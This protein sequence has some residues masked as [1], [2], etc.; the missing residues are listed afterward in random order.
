[1]K[2]QIFHSDK[3][4]KRARQLTNQSLSSDGLKLSEKTLLITGATQGIGHTLALTATLAGAQTLLLDKSIPALETLYE[5]IMGLSGTVLEPYLLP[6]D[7]AGATLDDYLEIAESLKQEISC[8]DGVIHNAAHF[9]GLYA[10][11]QTPP[12]DL[13]KQIQ[14][15]YTAPIW[16][17]QAMFP[18][19]KA[20]PQPT[21][22]FA[23][24]QESHTTDSAY[25]NSYASS[26]LALMQ[27]V[28]Q[29][30]LEN[31]HS[32]L[33]AY[34]YNSG[35]VNTL[36][37]R[38]AFPHGCSDWH[39]AEDA[40]LAGKILRLFYRQHPNGSVIDLTTKS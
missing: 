9:G 14:V 17:T 7:L 1:M 27:A 4:K 10:L 30:A 39:D 13:I 19:L 31:E 20:A 18:L 38:Q 25:Y 34:G 26:K 40:A 24:H 33:V 3:E 32:Q 15:N 8:L 36:L 23:D 6:V 11:L 2:P 28:K 12:E 22:L 35:W 29:L 21:V 37:A 16:L 5:D